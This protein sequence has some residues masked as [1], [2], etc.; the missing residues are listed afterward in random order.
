MPR[1]NLQQIRPGHGENETLHRCF[2]ADVERTPFICEAITLP[3]YDE[4]P[5]VFEL[6]EGE[7]LEFTLRSD[8]PI[9]VLLCNIANYEQWVDSDYDPEIAL[10]IHIEAEDVLSHKLRFTA[11]QAGEYAVLL[12]NWM[13]CPADV[14]VEIPDF[15][16]PALR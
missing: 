9:D 11:P 2:S 7:R 5:Y 4:L 12:M 13:E 1:M 14:V 8:T 15:L 10:L 3:A 16:A 6:C